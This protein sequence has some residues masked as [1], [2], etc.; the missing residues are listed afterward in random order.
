MGPK[1]EY[2]TSSSL[3]TVHDGIVIYP[4]AVLGGGFSKVWSLRGW[5][6]DR[7]ITPVKIGRLQMIDG[8]AVSHDQ[9]TL[10]YQ[11][12]VDN[13]VH[14]SSDQAHFDVSSSANHS[15]THHLVLDPMMRHTLIGFRVQGL[16]HG[17]ND[18][19]H[20]D[21]IIRIQSSANGPGQSLEPMQWLE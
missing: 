4:G 18:E 21:A 8:P 14:E 9:P 15:M 12:L 19:A 1:S 7:T 2:I 10:A 5:C 13:L 17:S 16:V 3:L 20:F 6:D 11:L